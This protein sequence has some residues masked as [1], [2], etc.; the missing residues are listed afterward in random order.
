MEDLP[1]AGAAVAASD[2]SVCIFGQTAPEKNSSRGAIPQGER[3]PA[4]RGSSP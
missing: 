3:V 2:A 4:K 1:G